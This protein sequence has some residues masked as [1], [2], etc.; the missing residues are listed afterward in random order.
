MIDE[1]I[2]WSKWASGFEYNTPL[3]FK[4]LLEIDIT[5]DTS[6]SIDDLFFALTNEEK[7][8]RKAPESM[9]AFWNSDDLIEKLKMK[10]TKEN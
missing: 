5:Q 1:I 2:I 4:I 3:L 10:I 7:Y 9:K 8:L 6:S